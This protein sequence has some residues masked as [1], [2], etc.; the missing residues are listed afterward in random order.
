MA[1]HAYF[2]VGESDAGVEKA[3]SFAARELGLEG[4]SHPDIFEG[5]YGLFSVDDSRY[6]GNVAMKSPLAGDRKLLIIAASRIF[7]E[8]QN[9]L[10]KLFEEPPEGTTLILVIPSEGLLLPTLRSRLIVLP[11]AAE[12]EK[13]NGKRVGGFAKQFLE[14]NSTEQEK[15]IAKLL[16]RTKSDKDEEKQAARSEAIQLVEG[17]THSAHQAWAAAKGPEKENLSLFLRDLERFLPILHERSAPLKLIFEHLLI[18]L[19]KTLTD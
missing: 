14:A 15:I 9:A 13:H 8:A 6:V 3:R 7:H 1:H 11:Q 4:V 16:E 5:R 12:S 19:P 17:L 18:V 2:V 10:L